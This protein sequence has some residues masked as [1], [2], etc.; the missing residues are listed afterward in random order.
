MTVTDPTVGL[1]KSAAEL[2]AEVFARKITSSSLDAAIEVWIKRVARRKYTPAQRARLLKA[3]ER[4]VAQETKDIQ[5][6]RAALMRAVG[7]DEAPA[8]A[9]AAAAGATYAE[10]GAVLGISQQGA[11]F[12]VRSY[13]ADSTANAMWSR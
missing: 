7:L 1:I 10:I 13:L 5:L 11:H 9:A 2:S 12:K 3:V 8:A 6:T 4:G